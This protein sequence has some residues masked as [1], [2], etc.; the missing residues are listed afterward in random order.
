[1]KVFY[2]PRTS[3]IDIDCPVAQGAEIIGDQ[4]WRKVIGVT[5]S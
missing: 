2:I 5:Y 3:F 1:M 4:Q